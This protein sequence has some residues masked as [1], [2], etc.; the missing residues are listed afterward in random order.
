MP[1]TIHNH[2]P[3]K[4]LE[5]YSLEELMSFAEGA[6]D[7]IDPIKLANTSPYDVGCFLERLSSEDQQFILNKL[8]SADASLVLA[9]MYSS[10]SAEILSEMRDNCAIRILENLEPDDAVDLLL[11]VEVHDRERLLGKLSQEFAETIRNLMRYD[12]DSAGGVMTPYVTTLRETMTVEQAIQYIRSE[13]NETE[14]SDILFVIDHGRRLIGETSVRNLI[15]AKSQQ[16]IADIMERDI[17]G[18]CMPGESK[19][20]VA[21]I[22]T[23]THGQTLPVIDGQGRLLGIITHDDVIDILHETATSDMQKLYG[24]GGDERVTD[25]IWY[26]ASR[27]M[28]WLIVNLFLT[29][30]TT[31]IMG[32]FET[33]IQNIAGLAAFLN[34]VMVLADNASDQVLAVLVRG[35]ALGEVLP[36]EVKRIYIKEMAKGFINGAVLG[37]LAGLL[38]ALWMHSLLMG[39]LVFGTLVFNM[40]IG[41]ILGTLV[42]TFLKKIGLDPASSSGIIMTAIAEP[43]TTLTFLWAGAIFLG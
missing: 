28:P 35:L 16:L 36:S 43:I 2:S 32:K 12:P 8:S 10:D 42:P 39:I 37:L 31:N 4:K 21:L 30:I 26:S 27:R 20:A 23:E 13:K 29:M 41:G 33:Q 11:D 14:N 9:E 22:M 3:S 25:G 18:I 1:H 34:L 6:L 17:H 24:A 5:Q 7:G 40:T 19:Q 38:A 15:W